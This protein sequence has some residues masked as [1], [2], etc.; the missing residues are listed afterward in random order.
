M[1]FE[2]AVKKSI[3]AFIAGKMPQELSRQADTE[4]MFTPEYF[5][6]MESDLDLSPSEE[7]SE[8]ESA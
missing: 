5:D 4:I 1:R 2:D 7:E 8:D 6:K 3:K